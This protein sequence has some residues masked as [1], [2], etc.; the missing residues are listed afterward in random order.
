MK[1]R[2]VLPSALWTQHYLI[3]FLFL[4]KPAGSPGCPRRLC[5]DGV[6]EQS[7]LLCVVITSGQLTL[8]LCS[9]HPVCRERG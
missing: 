1:S 5:W 7:G 3:Y 2:A 4:N 8:L 9:E 6:S